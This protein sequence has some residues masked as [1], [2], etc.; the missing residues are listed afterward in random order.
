[1]KGADRREA[2]LHGGEGRIRLLYDLWYSNN[3]LMNSL[4]TIPAISRGIL[5]QK[6]SNATVPCYAL[7]RDC[8]TPLRGKA[9][10]GPYAAAVPTALGHQ[11]VW[12]KARQGRSSMTASA[13][14]PLIT[15]V[16][17]IRQVPAGSFQ[18]G[19]NRCSA[20]P[21][22]ARRLAAYAGRGRPHWRDRLP[23]PGPGNR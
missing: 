15:S 13:V 19:V 16:A 12:A 17:R 23:P 10:L 8:G 9:V 4:A 11:R 5:Q 18:A 20:S 21:P 1:M 22:G 7:Q 14:R 3:L 2:L 6:C